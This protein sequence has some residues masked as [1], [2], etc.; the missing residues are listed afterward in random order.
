MIEQ[1]PVKQEIIEEKPV[2]IPKDAPPDAENDEPSP[3]PLGLDDAGQGTGRSARTAGRHGLHGAGG[4][5]GGGG[6][7]LGLVREHRAVA[8]RS[9]A[10][11]ERERPGTRSMQVQVRLWSDGT[12]RVN[13]VQLVVVDRQCRA[14]RDHPR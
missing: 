11:R 1:T 13:R 7:P 5:G 2:D 9:R 4:G 8:D 10:A 14:R 6:T 3:G 12:G